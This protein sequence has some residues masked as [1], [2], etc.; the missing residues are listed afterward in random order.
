MLTFCSV[1]LVLFWPGSVLVVFYLS[2]RGKSMK[3]LFAASVAATI[4]S[5]SSALALTV[6]TNTNASD[7]ANSILGT[8]VTII[9]SSYTGAGASGGTFTNGGVIGIDDGIILASGDVQDAPGPNQSDG[10]T[11]AFGTPGDADLNAL[12]PQNTQDAAFLEI[13]FTTDSG[14][15]FF[16]YAFA[17]EEYNEFTNSTFNDVFGLFLNGTN[18][19][20]IP[21]TMTP[22]SINTVNGG[23]P[24]GTGA[25]NSQFFNN[26]DLQDGGPFFDIEYD[27]FTDVFTASGTGLGTGVN[28]LKFAIADAGDQSLDSAIFIKGGSLSDTDPD[29]DPNPNVVPLPAGFPLMLAGFGAL[30]MM[31][32]KKKA[33]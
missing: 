11:T 29:P 31:R 6:T 27:G 9:S 3:Q 14:N 22:V 30:A 18:I 32:R 17:S 26:N 12:I 24:F 16:D 5:T 28:T 8:G 7:L 15:I 20:L 13:T 2:I 21:G 1:G 33:S 4:L 25:S 19:A 10:Q 23:N